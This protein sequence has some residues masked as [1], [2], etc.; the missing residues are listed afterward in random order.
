MKRFSRFAQ[1][2]LCGFGLVFMGAAVLFASSSATAQQKTL[3]IPADAEFDNLDPRVLTSTNH[4]LVQFGI[5]EPLVRTHEGKLLPG[6]ASSWEISKDG[7]TYTFHLRDAKW[8]DGKAVTAG[9]FVHAFVRM[10]QICPAS[11][12]YDDIKNGAELRAGKVKPSDLGVQAPND[13]TVVITLKNPVP[14]FMELIASS[15]GAPGREDLVKKYGEGYGASAESL[16]SNGPFILK[17]WK[18]NDKI[19]MVKNPDYWNAKEIKLDQVVVYILPNAQTQR[20]L[21]DNGE[22]DMYIPRS[23]AEANYYRTKGL[24]KEYPRGGIRDLQ[25]NRHGQNDPIKAKI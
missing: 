16:A 18:K 10:F 2:A 3:Y 8:S 11:P 23:E 12:I 17:E 19:V 15:F 5:F 7:M 24:L 22:L 13:K 4:Q 9:D 14:Y 20:N 25:L 1:I 6:M 21:F